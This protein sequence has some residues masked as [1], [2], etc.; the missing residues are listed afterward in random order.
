MVSRMFARAA[1]GAALSL[2]L[3]SS[4][5]YAS[6]SRNSAEVPQITVRFADLN[7]NSEEGLQRLYSRI[8]VASDRVCAA[9]G[10]NQLAQKQA[11]RACREAAI[12]RAIANVDSP[13]LTALLRSKSGVRR[14]AVL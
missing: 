6:D 2:A 12:D 4:Q 5:A 8:V 1:F 7:L 3:L 11:H 9:T 14:V 13:N 10:A